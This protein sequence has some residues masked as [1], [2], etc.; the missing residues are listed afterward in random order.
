MRLFASLVAFAGGFIA[1]AQQGPAPAGNAAPPAALPAAQA[2]DPDAE[3]QAPAQDAPLPTSP[4][5][6][7]TEAWLDARGWLDRG[8]APTQPRPVP[9][10]R[11]IA[12]SIRRDGTLIGVGESQSSSD[13]AR[14]PD[15]ADGARAADLADA[16]RQ[17]INEA[18]RDTTLARALETDTTAWTRLS[19]E[20]ELAGDPVPLAGVNYEQAA[21]SIDPGIDGMAVRRGPRWLFTMPG[22]AMSLEVASDPAR[23]F[24]GMASRLGVPMRDLPDLLPAE[25]PALYRVPVTR[26]VQPLDSREPVQVVRFARQV[27]TTPADGTDAGAQAAADR[28]ADWLCG[29]LH[30]TTSG[31]DVA[32]GAAVLENLGLRGDWIPSAG[33]HEPMSALPADQALAAL[34][35]ARYARTA[36]DTASPTANR[37]ASDTDR[38]AAAR[39]AARRILVALLRVAPVERDP[40]QDRNAIALGVMAAL[41]LKNALPADAELTH[42]RDTLI[43]EFLRDGSSTAWMTADATPRMR[44]AEIA[45]ACSLLASGDTRL[46]AA[47]LRSALDAAWRDIPRRDLVSE[48]GWLLWSERALASAKVPASNDARDHQELA[49]ST[50][51]ALSRAQIA[52]EISNGTVAEDP[53]PDDLMGGFR[54][55]GPNTR[56]ATA[57]SAR[58]ML[59]LAL[60]LDNPYLT[61]DG[62]R[63]RSREMQRMAVRFLRQLQVDDVT[64]ASIPGS[65]RC[66]GALRSAPW[67]MR[68]SVA[69]NSTALLALTES[70]DGMISLEGVIDSSRSAPATSPGGSP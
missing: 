62:E 13:G 30:P 50:R 28:V 18:R 20:L 47:S 48:L 54:L 40:L 1:S 26:L 7:A 36:P 60:M 12:V 19:L 10:A 23:T 57:Q 70:H 31:M 8:E 52:P 11:V 27:V 43:R 49:R 42:A 58:P 61:P 6:T 34:A 24:V 55:A 41:E 56:G 39:A 68:L 16:V 44:T 29:H 51:A 35:L 21:R 33:V 37:N 22:R 63:F 5:I 65:R 46:D 14:P 4:T 17:A 32:E 69:A 9:G 66:L 3:P 67:E 38:A 45:A 59:G 15:L 25:T 2:V 53:F 64:A